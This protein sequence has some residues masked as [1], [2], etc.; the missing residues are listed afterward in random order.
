MRYATAVNIS[1]SMDL[2]NCKPLH[3]FLMRM[4]P[5]YCILAWHLAVRR[6]KALFSTN[7]YLKMANEYKEA[8]AA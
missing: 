1:G 2:K 7:E 3:Q 8:F 6:D 4:E 5:T